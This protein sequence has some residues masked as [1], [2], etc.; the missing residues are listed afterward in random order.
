MG[1][2]LI[3]SPS[4]IDSGTVDQAIVFDRA[5]EN[6]LASSTGFMVSNKSQQAFSRG[7]F[8]ER[9]PSQRRLRFSGSL[10]TREL[11]QTWPG[12]GMRDFSW[13]GL[14]TLQS[15]LILGVCMVKR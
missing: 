15:R 3:I 8:S 11:D 1:A 7:S 5:G 2:R 9:Y 14:S 4:L 13:P 10:A 12:P 6:V